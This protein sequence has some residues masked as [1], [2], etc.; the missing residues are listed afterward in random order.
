MLWGDLEETSISDGVELRYIS[1]CKMISYGG[2]SS[3]MKVYEVN[4]SCENHQSRYL[5]RHPGEVCQRAP[6]AIEVAS[7]ICHA[8][9]RNRSRGRPCTNARLVANRRQLCRFPAARHPVG[10]TGVEYRL[11]FC[12]LVVLQQQA[13]VGHE[14]ERG[15]GR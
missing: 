3:G 9:N 12:I 10:Q 2:Y 7:S 11:L 4:C 6:N 1:K 14:S 13:A 5:L 8:T 15:A